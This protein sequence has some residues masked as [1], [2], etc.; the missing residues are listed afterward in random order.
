MIPDANHD[1]AMTLDA[2]VDS[3]SKQDRPVVLIEGTREPLPAHIPVMTEFA[4]QLARRRPRAIFRSGNAAGSD[5]AFASGI[6]AVDATRLQ[7]VTPYVGHRRHARCAQSSTWAL[8]GVSSA[9]LE[10]IAERTSGA[11]PRYRDA[12]AA[13]R[14]GILPRSALVKLEYLL[15]DT[16]KV[17]GDTSVGLAPATVAFFYVHPK[18]PQAGGTGHTVRVCQLVGVPVFTQADWL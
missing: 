11:S 16:M 2:F 9:A 13:Y 17:V 14:R 8:P 18:R 15:R 3:L 6:E 4:R 12:V 5:D 1:R 7:L 10:T